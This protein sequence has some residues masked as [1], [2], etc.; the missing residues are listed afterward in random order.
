MPASYQNIVTTSLHELD[1][2]RQD[3]SFAGHSAP[4]NTRRNTAFAVRLYNLWKKQGNHTS[5]ECGVNHLIAQSIPRFFMEI[6][7]VNGERYSASTMNNVFAALNRYLSTEVTP[8]VNMYKSEDFRECCSKVERIVRELQ[9]LE[10]NTAAKVRRILSPAHEEKLW[11][12]NIL[13]DEKPLQ[14]V[15]TLLFLCGKYFN[16]TG[17]DELRNLRMD[18]FKFSYNSQNGL[19]DVTYERGSAPHGDQRSCCSRR[20]NISQKVVVHPENGKKRYSFTRLFNKYLSHIHPQA[21]TSAAL[22]FRPSVNTLTSAIEE[23]KSPDVWYIVA[24]MGKNTLGAYLKNMMAEIGLHEGFT[25][26]SLRGSQYSLE[27][28]KDA[29]P[30]KQDELDFV[31]SNVPELWQESSAVSFD[32]SGITQL[33]KM[34]PDRTTDGDILID[35]ISVCNE[36]PEESLFSPNSRMTST[37]VSVPPTGRLMVSYDTSQL[38]LKTYD[39]HGNHDNNKCTNTMLTLS[40]EL[41]VLMSLKL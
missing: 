14:L 37:E 1:T 16:V 15:R 39:S 7:K 36:T 2:L 11:E 29:S 17:G 28:D 33:I 3:P 30:R 27:R 19:T 38:R 23:V 4:E 40:P 31:E 34:E 13:G 12:K 24:P 25:N 20:V 5:L 22:W 21:D 9:E 32:L 8:S 10:Q 35:P 41:D 18:R 26:H 6:R